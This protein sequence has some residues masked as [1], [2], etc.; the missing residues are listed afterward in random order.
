MSKQVKNTA[1]V[2]AFFDEQKI[3]AQLP[4]IRI[5]QQPILLTKRKIN[6]LGYKCLKY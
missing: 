6:R 2:S 5:T 1:A 3:N 4:A